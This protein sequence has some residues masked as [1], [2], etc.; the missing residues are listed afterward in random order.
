MVE[1]LSSITRRTEA[2]DACEQNAKW[3]DKEDVYR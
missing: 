1:T 2:E 3:K